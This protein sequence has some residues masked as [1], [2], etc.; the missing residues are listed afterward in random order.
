MITFYHVSK[1]YPGEQLALDDVCLTIERGELVVVTGSS[2]AGKSSLLKCMY[3]ELIPDAGEVV[4]ES[5]RSSMITRHEIPYLRRQ[6]GIVFQDFKLLPDRS[7]LENVAFALRITGQNDRRTIRELAQL[8]LH[9][10]G[11]HHRRLARPRELSGG[12]QQRVAIARALVNDPVFLLADEPTGNLDHDSGREVLELL[13]EINLGGT[14]VVIATHA[15][16][17]VDL[18]RARHLV[19]EAGRVQEVPTAPRRR[20]GSG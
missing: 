19:V 15:A 4:V 14:G 6:L 1:S 8:A 3:M 10:V 9:R 12:E 5:F 2:G 13:G 18:P 16:G 17:A 11:L 20:A 7:I